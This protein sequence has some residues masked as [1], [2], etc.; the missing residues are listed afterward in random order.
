MQEETGATLS[1]AGF[2]CDED[3][4]G[5]E[6]IQLAMLVSASVLCSVA[7][8]HTGKLSLMSFTSGIIACLILFSDC[9]KTAVRRHL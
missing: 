7:E 5:D 9:L 3:V 6:C 1:R 4:S 2:L 8:G